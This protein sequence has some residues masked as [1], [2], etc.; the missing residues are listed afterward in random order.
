MDELREEF[1]AETRETLEILAGQLV[2][3]EKTPQ[4]RQLI[5]EAFRFVHTVKGSCGFLD[6]PRLMRLSH[7]AEEVLSVARD[8]H[9]AVNPALVTATLAV[10]DR[11]GALTDALESGRSVFDDDAH[12]IDAMLLFLPD[13][14]DPK[15]ASPE[16][17][18]A[19]AEAEDQFASSDDA[20]IRN[21]ARTVRVSLSL[22]D[23]LMNNVSD[24][25]LARNEVSRQLRKTG[26]GSEVDHSFARLSS[27]VAEIR[28]AIGLMRMQHIDRLFSSLPRLL[29]DI[30]IELDKRIELSIEGSEVE[31]DREMVEALRDPLTHILRNAADHGIE[32]PELRS[33]MGKDPVGHIS[34]TARQSGNQIVIEIVDD[35]RGVD[36]EKLGQR[37][38]A[39]KLVTPT[40]WQKMTDQ[41]K[42][43][44]VFAPGVSTAEN[45]TAI[46]GRG[47]GMDVVRANMVGIGGTI[48]LENDEGHGLK[49]VLRLPLTLSIIAGLSLRAG[50]QMFGISRSSV[51]EIVSLAN[52]QVEL[53]TIGGVAI[54]KVRGERMAY[55]LLEDVLELDPASSAT[56]SPR[57][58]VIV[59]PAVGA[60]FALDVEAVVDH[61]ELV[62][63]PGAPLVMSTGLFAGTTL[64]D[65]GR[66]MLLLDTSGLAAMIGVDR[67]LFQ[68]DDVSKARQA[69]D[70]DCKGV[71]GL[72]FTTLCGKT[73]AIRLSAVER[74]EDI[75][76]AAIHEIGERLYVSVSDRLHELF[77]LKL[78][79]LD[80]TTK[81]LRISDG[82]NM[83]FLAVDD[84]AD[85]FALAS[86][87]SP[88]PRPD[89]YE[90]IIHVGGQPVELLSVFRFFE[91]SIAAAPHAAKPL[92]FIFGEQNESWESRML[93]PLLVAAGYQISFDEGTRRC[94]P[95]KQRSRHGPATRCSLVAPARCD[96]WHFGVWCQRL[97]LRPSRPVICH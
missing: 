2:Q 66:P 94:D 67:E 70:V 81:V 75:D 55:A 51:V 47:V 14:S 45:I 26:N 1:I 9:I 12:L 10:I 35:G 53:E 93:A 78:K 17:N 80:G 84:V 40:Q 65:N 6:L 64:P 86:E 85:I 57:T 29:R 76:N 24:L 19:S 69:G 59:R 77:G 79:P 62:V 58:L 92:C 50:G 33:A 11:I 34:V 52:R 42:L 5:D 83:V 27:T 68:R 82:T 15:T 31:V 20:F 72:L 22:L 46:S 63:K 95:G 4:D 16:A 18:P 32:S 56:D 7:A 39:R 71:S 36:L 21:K 61:E 96:S 49:I 54:A 87:I 30:C 37:S 13:R 97:S 43:E 91:T 88:S 74:M 28:D 90:G 25:V 3:W 23:N 8:G 38:I 89:L 41:Q 44:M 48:D 60:K 73:H